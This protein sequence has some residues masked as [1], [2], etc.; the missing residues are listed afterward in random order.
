MKRTLI[1]LAMVLL[2][3]PL[4][5]EGQAETTSGEVEQV[6]HWTTADFGTYFDWM[7]TVYNR[8][9]Q[10][11]AVQL[12]LTYYDKNYELN[13]LGAES[14]EVS[15]DGLTW[16]ITLRDGLKW[17]DGTDLTAS[18]YAFA[19]I[20]A[21]RDGYDFGWYWSWAAAVSNWT[22]FA[23]GE[24]SVEE[25][26]VQAIDDVTLQVT[27]DA[28]K[29]YFDGIVSVWFPVPE[30]QVE[31]YGD[32]YATKAETM[33]CSGPFVLTEWIKGE[34]MV[35][36]RNELYNGPWQAEVDKVILYPS[37]NS[38]D[39]GFPAYL[40]GELDY[41]SLNAGQLA[42]AQRQY[43][44][45]IVSNAAFVDYYLS[46]DVSQPPFDDVN[47][48]K[49]FLYSIN[50]DEVTSTLLDG[51]AV[52]A[53]TLLPIGFPGYNE[54]I[55]EQV[56]FDPEMAKEALAAGGYPN[57]DGFPKITF[58]YRQEGGSTQ[59]VKPLAEYLQSQWKEILGIDVEI[60]YGDVSTWMTALQNNTYE[61]FLS[62]YAYDYVDP[63]NWFNIF[64]NPGSRHNWTNEEYNELVLEANATNDWETRK[65]LYKQAEE[66]LILQEA[67]IAPMIH[68]IQHFLLNPKLEGE[69]SEPNDAGYYPGTA[70]YMWTHLSVG[71]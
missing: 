46:Y 70:L 62:P 64:V 57:G 43:P 54:E 35:L 49:A 10:P 17:S 66:I 29:P 39:V 58:Y 68:P 11:D 1:V 2:A 27:T 6:L 13:Y 24:V 51:L 7:K 16:T 3:L 42:L 63:S 65:E 34:R 47:V 56:T 22:A 8:V 25:F 48:R 53:K 19:L 26:G 30:H 61:L 36:E 5:A 67:A 50:R 41:T 52:P 40:A 44:D 15:D 28:P 20:R 21:A 32:E 38:A 31:K 59:L 12:P 71:R 14:M 37:L 55:A 69:G 60:G 33:V 18:D 23:N 9:G 45:E 4:F